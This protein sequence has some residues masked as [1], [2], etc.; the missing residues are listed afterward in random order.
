V[1]SR[2]A[3]WGMWALSSVLTALSLLLLVLTFSHLH[4]EIFDYWVESTVIPLSC[5]TVG[6]LVASRRPENTTGWIFCAIGLAAAVRHFGAEY[7]IYAL[8]AEPG[9]LPYGEALAWITSWIRVPYFS[10]FVFVALVFPSGRLPTGRWR[11]VAWLT[12]IVV[13]VGT[14]LVAVSPGATRGLGPIRNPFAIESVPSVARL[15]E[16]LIF[17][18]GIVEG[19]PCLRGCATQHGWSA[20]RSNGSPTLLQ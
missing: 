1:S 7:A 8:L 5:S 3:A 10:F 19:S 18:L 14:I 9:S 6:A 13:A 15:V 17:A 11:W 2:T 20:S 16:T 12:A 4:V